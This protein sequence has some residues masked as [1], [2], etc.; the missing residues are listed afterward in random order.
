MKKAFILLLG[1][2][3]LGACSE[4]TKNEADLP[5]ANTYTLVFFDKTQSVNP[6]DTFVKTKYSS[7]IRN[8]V[9]QNIRT[10]GDILEVYFI[11]ENTSKARALTVKSRTAK[12]STE[13]LSPT[14]L[15]AASNAYDLSIKKER[16]MIYN[17]LM[18]KLMESNSS[19]SN[20][21]TNISA[22][23]PVIATALA[24]YPDVKAYFFSD[25]VES[26]RS[27]RDFHSRPPQN[28]E[29]A[30]S[31]ARED[32]GKYAQQSLSGAGIYMILPFSPNSSSKIN[33]PNVTEY[34][35]DFF[36]ELGTGN[37]TEQ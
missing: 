3:L 26:M 32:A 14:D 12:E 11:H 20:S 25:M 33:N 28:R 10:E 13:G 15:E 4:T 1:G 16:Q 22:G 18:Q 17:A 24:T 35:K 34:W 7:A 37:V 21:E 19:A 2:I 36:G 30:Q 8:L 27:G 31:W 23:I 6:N 29:Q 9:D 5:P